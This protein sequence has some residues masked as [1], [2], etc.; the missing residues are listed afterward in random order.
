VNENPSRASLFGALL[1]AAGEGVY[2][3]D[4]DGLTTFVNPAAV[5][6]L[7]WPAGEL[8]GQPMHAS[9]HHSHPDGSPF[10]PEECLIYAAFKD[11]QVHHVEDEH[12]WRKDG[13]C[14]PVEYTSTPSNCLARFG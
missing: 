1:Q 2:G 7:G 3:L 9:L 6:M 5:R 11:G 14:F 8:V 13:T 12:F 10:P 4:C